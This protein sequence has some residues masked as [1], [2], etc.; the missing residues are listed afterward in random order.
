M[1]VKVIGGYD[2][3]IAWA[4]S[5]CLLV[6]DHVAFDSG[7]LASQLNLHEQVAVDHVFITHSHLDHIGELAFL[8]DNVLTVRSRPL[9]VWGPAPILKQVHEHLFN[10][11]IWPDL[12]NIEVGGQ[13]VLEFCPIAPDESVEIGK[14]TIR[15]RRTNHPVFSAGYLIED[16]NGAILYTGDTGPTEAIWGLANQV[17]LLHAVFTETAFPDRLQS[18]AID[19]GHLTPT[20]LRHELGKLHASKSVI[21]VMHVKPVYR[22]EVY[23]GLQTLSHLWQIDLNGEIFL[24]E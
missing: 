14:L 4:R 11:Q 19:A 6:D 24:F 21:H 16:S 10:N 13:P 8:A 15:W 7:G 12:S 17:D 20:L 18:L 2:E 5:G 1:H 23:K 9:M 22:E 3:E